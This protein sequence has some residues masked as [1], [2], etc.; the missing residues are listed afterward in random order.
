MSRREG[1]Q[2]YAKENAL[3]PITGNGSFSFPSSN[4]WSTTRKTPFLNR[5][6]RVYK[7]QYIFRNGPEAMILKISPTNQL[8]ISA[9]S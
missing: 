7:Q 3:S 6:V 5:N 4:L 1:Q 2:K 8:P 9:V